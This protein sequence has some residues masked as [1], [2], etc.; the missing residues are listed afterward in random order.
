MSKYFEI[1]IDDIDD[2]TLAHWAKHLLIQQIKF[3]KEKNTIN[4]IIEF[5]KIPF[6]TGVSLKTKNVNIKVEDDDQITF[7][8]NRRSPCVKPVVIEL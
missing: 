5:N 1:Y 6:E 3:K 7:I 8:E 4:I 2:L